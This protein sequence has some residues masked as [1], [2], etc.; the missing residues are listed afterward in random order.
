MPLITPTLT[1][2]PPALLLAGMPVDSACN[3]VASNGTAG[4]VAGAYVYTPPAGTLVPGP[5]AG[6]AALT[7]LT[8]NVTFTP[9]DGMTYTVATAA[10]TIPV[11]LAYC[12][13][14]EARGLMASIPAALLGT[15]ATQTDTQLAMLLA[16][17]SEDIDAT[18]PYQGR[19]YDPTQLREFPRIDASP[20]ARQ[21]PPAPP[22]INDPSFYVF[23]GSPTFIFD[24]DPAA[25]NGA[26]AAVVPNKVKIAT[27]F[28]AAWLLR[29]EYAARLEGIHSGLIEQ[30]IGTGR[31]TYVKKGDT[32]FSGL[33]KR[34]EQMMDKNYRR[35][36]G[37]LL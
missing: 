12:V 33:G 15:L 10:V 36:S 27:I 18:M 25:G 9:A 5:T 4:A 31:E 32:G 26:G 6:G 37:R 19:K 24:W 7:P 30:S 3:A 16:T 34:A 2:T 23:G 14:S 13:P 8:I 17:A 28:Q 20:S 21:Y 11:A 29:P 35:R 22:S 1:W